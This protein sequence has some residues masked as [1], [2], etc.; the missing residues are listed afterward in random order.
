[1][2]A[3]DPPAGV[4]GAAD[5]VGGAGQAAS[6]AVVAASKEREEWGVSIVPVAVKV[7]HL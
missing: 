7:T 2:V 4:L 5:A 6:V 3:R 1:L